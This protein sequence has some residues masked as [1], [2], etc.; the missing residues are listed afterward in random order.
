MVIENNLVLIY[1]GF[2]TQRPNSAVKHQLFL[3]LLNMQIS[4]LVWHRF[5]VEQS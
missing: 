3:M 1:C 5:L 2:Y 4:T